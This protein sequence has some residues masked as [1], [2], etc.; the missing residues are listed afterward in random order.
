M[1]RRGHDIQLFIAGEGSARPQLEAEI[2][3][4]SLAD[5]VKLLGQVSDTRLLLQATD[6]FVLSSLREGLP[7][8]LLEAMAMETPVVATRIAGV[9]LL[10]G[11]GAMGVL[12][13]PASSEELATGIERLVRDAELRRRLALLARQRIEQEYSFERRMQRVAALY[14]RLLHR[15]DALSNRPRK[16]A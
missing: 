15:G 10:L 5:R 16:T 11:D 9:P 12:V 4:N 2:A 3:K 14:D 7:N 6:L 8:V 13:E 1:L